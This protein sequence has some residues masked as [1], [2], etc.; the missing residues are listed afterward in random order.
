MVDDKKTGKSKQTKLEA[1]RAGYYEGVYIGHLKT[2]LTVAVYYEKDK[3]DRKYKKM[4]LVTTLKKQS[5]QQLKKAYGHRWAIEEYFKELKSKYDL[6]NFR[7]RKFKAIERMVKLVMIAQAVFT[8][9]LLE[10]TYWVEQM[11][12]ILMEFL[13]YGEEI[14]KNGISLLREIAFRLA[15]FG[16]MDDFR[17]RLA[18]IQPFPT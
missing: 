15:H 11:Q 9:S 12:H 17:L 2:K 16:R 10:N 6:E 3:K 7:V 18:Q 4:I 5:K 14:T 1:L 8:D 13:Y